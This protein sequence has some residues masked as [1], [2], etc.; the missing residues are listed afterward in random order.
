[1]APLFL[2]C[3]LGSID[4]AVWALQQSA[5]VSAVEAGAR[6]AASAGGSPA[7]TTAPDARAVAATIADR[8]GP[9]LFATRLV[10]WCGDAASAPHCAP[11]PCPPSPAVVEATYG[12][13]VLAV[14]LQTQRVAPCTQPPSGVPPPYPPYC[15][16]TPTVTVRLVGFVAALV[17]PG[18]GPGEVGGELPT[19][20][21]AT[22]H[23]LRFAP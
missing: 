6:T 2:L 11:A 5:E 23:T 22:T 9:A 4:A 15:N 12:P 14:C 19:D 10:A 8:L 3:L 16:D 13:R 7:G 17:P 20:I 1:M 21:V 18:F